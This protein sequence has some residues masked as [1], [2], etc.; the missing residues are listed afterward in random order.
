MN[1]APRPRPVFIAALPREIASLVSHRG[2]R[3]YQKLLSRNIHLFEHDDAILA[4]AG[5][6]ADRAALAVEAALKLG[7]ASELIS[8]GWAGA[9]NERLHV[10]DIVHADIV[11]DTR[12]GERFFTGEGTQPQTIQTVVTVASPAS[13]QEKQR[14]GAAYSASAVDME[15]AAVAR[16]ARARELPF[17]AI[18][19][20]S[21][22]VTFELPDLAQFA[23][24]DGQFR[25]A[26]FGLHVALRPTLWASVLAMAKGSKLAAGHLCAEVET[27]MHPYRNRTT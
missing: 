21:D 20:I 24:Q 6:G 23:T 22:D 17:Y 26:A 13:A 3:A 1:T 10:G 11:V 4:C 19:A 18:K 15:A 9:C 27:H 12:T 2:W 16:L 8:I 7:P 5:M 25:E 14:L